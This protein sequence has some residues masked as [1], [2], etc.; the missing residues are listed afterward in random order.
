MGITG[1]CKDIVEVAMKI[2]LEDFFKFPMSTYSIYVDALNVA[3]NDVLLRELEST[4]TRLLETPRHQVYLWV[5]FDNFWTLKDLASKTTGKDARGCPQLNER[6]MRFM[7]DKLSH[8]VD[9]LVRR[10]DGRLYVHWGT[11]THNADFETAN[12]FAF[13]ECPHGTMKILFSSDGDVLLQSLLNL[14]VI[15]DSYPEASFSSPVAFVSSG[16]GRRHARRVEVIYLPEG[17]CASDLLENIA[18]FRGID[19][20]FL[21]LYAGMSSTLPEYDHIE[22]ETWRLTRPECLTDP[23]LYA[24]PH[25]LD[26]DKGFETIHYA[27]FQGEQDYYQYSDRYWEVCLSIF[28]ENTYWGISSSEEETE[29]HRMNRQAMAEPRSFSAFQSHVCHQDTH[30]PSLWNSSVPVSRMTNIPPEFCYNVKTLPPSRVLNAIVDYCE[31]IQFMAHNRG[32]FPPGTEMCVIRSKF[33]NYQY[34]RLKKRGDSP[35]R[36]STTHADSTLRSDEQAKAIILEHLAIC[37]DL[38]N[39][40]APSRS[41][42]AERR[43]SQSLGYYL[44]GLSLRASGERSKIFDNCATRVRLYMSKSSRCRLRSRIITPEAGEVSVWEYY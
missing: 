24:S 34:L 25:M 28:V 38:R 10:A 32:R 19:A 29:I 3:C 26:L 35:V 22:R 37:E 8:L 39:D 44:D 23:S 1:I 11:S 20:K 30:V 4:A 43:R 16:T 40:A 15:P 31:I 7:S 21:E 12:R 9:E 41:S 27:L 2:P 18:T 5:I 42:G 14:T 33:G 6:D 13:T 17:V 36:D